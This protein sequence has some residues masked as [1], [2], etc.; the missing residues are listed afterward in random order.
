MSLPPVSSEC[1][2]TKLQ[3]PFYAVMADSKTDMSGQEQF[4]VCIRYV[5]PQTLDVHEAFLGMYNPPDSKA[6]TLFS[7]IK[8]VLTGLLLSFHNLKGH[9]FDGAASMSGKIGEVQKLIKDEQPKSM[10]VHCCIHSLNIALQEAGSSSQVIC[11]NIILNS[12]K[13]KSIYN[14]I[15]SAQCSSKCEM[16]MPVKQLLPLYTTR[17]FVHMNA[18]LR[19]RSAD[20]KP[21]SRDIMLQHGSRC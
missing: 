2:L 12:A 20:V 3:S 15:V 16:D 18:T 1:F 19:T 11:A 8:D 7:T 21:A 10:Y 4:F 17:W 13:R 6:A 5:S 9:C 14:G